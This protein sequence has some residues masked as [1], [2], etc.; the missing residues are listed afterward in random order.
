MKYLI[1]LLTT[2]H[3]FLSGDC[4]LNESDLSA[5]KIEYTWEGTQDLETIH[6][7]FLESF[8]ENYNRLGLKEKDLG[9]NDIR[10]VLND[11]WNEEVGSIKGQDV[12]WMVAK[13]GSEIVGYA[14]FN[15]KNAPEE[16]YIQ[17][18]CVKPHM[19]YH[20]IGKTLLN[21]IFSIVEKIDKMSLITRRVN[22]SAIAFYKRLGF[23]E[24]PFFN[25]KANID[26]ALCVQLEKSYIY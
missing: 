9:T 15:L 18:L 12:R 17:L 4:S 25:K 6:S 19:Q 24:I 22:T 3:C 11:Y 21:A 23:E 20:G 26:P 10:K 1:L 16:V 2:A 8:I 13:K 5:Q 7:L 14:S